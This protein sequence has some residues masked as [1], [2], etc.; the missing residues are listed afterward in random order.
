MS[1]REQFDAIVVGA[2]PAGEV[3]AG[4]LADGGL[5]VAIVERERVAGECSFWAC[6]PSKAL[7]RPGHVLAEAQRIP[8]AAEAAAGQLDVERALAWRDKIVSNWDDSG[9]VTWLTDRGI[10]LIR[11]DGR[12]VGDGGVDVEDRRLQ[13]EHIVIATGSVPSIPPIEGLSE[14]AFWTNR[15]ATGAHEIPKRLLII[16]AGAVGVELSQ[17]YASFGA[18]VALIDA[19]PHILPGE[20]AAVAEALS[21]VLRDEGVDIH[22]GTGIARVGGGESE[23][24]VLLE[25]GTELRGDAL[26]VATGRKPNTA[27]LG[28][29]SLAVKLE[30]GAIEVDARLRA[31]PGIYAIGDASGVNLTTHTGKYQARVCAAG[32]LGNG[33]DADYRA[34]PRIA[35]TDPGVA[36]VGLTPAAA[37]DQGIA[38]RVGTANFGDT[39]ASSLGRS[40]WRGAHSQ[41]LSLVAD[42]SGTIIGAYAVAPHAE[43][44]FGQL[45]LAVQQRV[46]AEELA[47]T[48]QPFPAASEVITLAA[49]ELL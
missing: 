45:I 17:A 3:V 34:I 47:R 25:D 46:T 39:A 28:L 9:Y 21:P 4:E 42:A 15:E 2:G 32:I 37:R 27:G 7:L 48:I 19:A 20:D 6:M 49:R 22:T 1:G 30:R 29:E 31:A 41:F 44:W 23:R 5:K 8:G 35:Y 14:T 40:D 12:L 26:L 43:D 18:S 10:E 36:G 16:G 13:A 38:A 11:G 24:Q 33:Y